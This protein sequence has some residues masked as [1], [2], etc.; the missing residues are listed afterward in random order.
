MVD[1]LRNEVLVLQ[2]KQSG[3]Y[4]S[5]QHWCPDSTSNLQHASQYSLDTEI[6]TTFKEKFHVRKLEIVYRWMDAVI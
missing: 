4:M 5:G 2:N 3:K 6:P 1:A